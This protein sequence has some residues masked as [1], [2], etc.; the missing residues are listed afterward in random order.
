MHEAILGGVL[1][2]G[3]IIL[4]LSLMKLVLK[5]LHQAHRMG[6]VLSY[7][8]LGLTLLLVVPMALYHADEV[9]I[10]ISWFSYLSLSVVGVIIE[11]QTV[12]ASRWHFD[13]TR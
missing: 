13:H 3:A 12:Y 5:V 6:E 10:W 2:N 8:N 1:F 4:F 7:V 9:P 11:R